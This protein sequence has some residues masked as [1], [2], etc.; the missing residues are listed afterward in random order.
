MVLAKRSTT[1]F[2]LRDRQLSGLSKAKEKT[3]EMRPAGHAVEPFVT[4]AQAKC[5]A[6]FDAASASSLT[7]VWPLANAISH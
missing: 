4:D 1:R 6:E 5:A 7:S 3:L 2:K